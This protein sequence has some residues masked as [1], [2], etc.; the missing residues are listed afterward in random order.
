MARDPVGASDI[1][2]LVIAICR[3]AGEIISSDQGDSD[4]FVVGVV[5]AGKVKWRPRKVDCSSDVMLGDMW[6]RVL[7]V[8]PTLPLPKTMMVPSSVV[9]VSVL[10]GDDF[11]SNSLAFELVAVINEASGWGTRS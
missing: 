10:W 11:G 8:P 9:T 7:P 2:T 6:S 1:A 5:I 4:S 3:G